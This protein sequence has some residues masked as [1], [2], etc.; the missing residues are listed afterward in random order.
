MGRFPK[1][2]QMGRD[3]LAVQCGSVGVKHVFSMA[4]EVIPY[5]G[6]QLNSRTIRSSMLVKYISKKNR[7]HPD[8]HHAPCASGSLGA[9]NL[10]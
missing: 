9:Y 4:R 3:I 2:A 5:L 1:L 7:L 10:N 6:S 8:A